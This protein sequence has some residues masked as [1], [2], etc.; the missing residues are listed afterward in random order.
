MK[1]VDEPL[2]CGISGSVLKQDIYLTAHFALRKD[3][4]R[5]NK[6]PLLSKVYEE[7]KHLTVQS[8]KTGRY[9]G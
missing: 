6:S 9:G 3:D 5:K 2:Q 7:V 1:A 8:P 4:L